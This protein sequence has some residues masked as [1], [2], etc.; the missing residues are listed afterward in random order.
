[1]TL[2]FGKNLKAL[3][4]EKDLTQDEL[5]Q[6]LSLSVQAISRYETGAAY[7]DVEML[8]VIAGFFG[9]SV[10]ALLGVSSKEKERRMD[11]Y[12]NELRT[13]TDRT[14]RLAL[15][16]K[17]H[18]EFPEEWSVTNGM[19]YEMTYLPECF[20]EMREIVDDALEHCGDPLWRENMIFSYLRCEPDEERA[21]DFIIKN[22][23]RYDMRR[24]HLL[25]FRYMTRKEWDKQKGVRQKMRMEELTQSL[26]FLSEKIDGDSEASWDGCRDVLSLIGRLSGSPDRT[27]PDMW[28]NVKL[29]VMLR[30]ANHCFML[31]ETDEGFSVLGDA[32]AL[33]ENLLSLPDGT[34][35]SY[36]SPRF[37]ALSAV[38][39]KKVYYQITEFSGMIASSVFMEL[40]YQTPVGFLEKD[41]KI[42]RDMEGFGG[43]TVFAGNFCDI[44]RYADQERFGW[45]GFAKVA[46]D[47][48]YAA[49]AA[50]AK[51]AALI[52]ET[53][54]LL[55]LMDSIRRRTDEFV[56][57]KKWA[58]ALV[59]AGVGA[60][61]IWDDAADIEEKFARMRREGNTRVIRAAA[62]EI[63]GDLIPLP[64][65]VKKKLIELDAEN[66][67]AKLLTRGADGAVAYGAV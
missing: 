27:N 18:A 50:R 41:P 62:V 44:L 39:K 16:R 20:G 11:E 45:T 3:R 63:G 53:D 23:S 59:V 7:P 24:V 32:V 51:A 12:T 58:C 26:Y 37:G 60:Y 56:T 40:S 30:L 31:D 4:R 61:V 1:M 15:L 21:N 2:T 38:T 52:E 66:A 8:P 67:D 28:I 55:F 13:L 22:A 57:D 5:A 17:E 9:V 65:V 33:L 42:I 48:R 19:V 6:K 64:E 35:L 47:A 34:V 14:Q 49:L 25:D 46:K 36:G 54:N 29:N 43:E 10:D